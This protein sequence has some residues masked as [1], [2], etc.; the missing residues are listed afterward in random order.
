MEQYDPLLPNERSECNVTA[1]SV[2]RSSLLRGSMCVMP[3]IRAAAKLITL[4]LA[5]TSYTH[6][7]LRQWLDL[8]IALYSFPPQHPT[9][10][11]KSSLTEIDVRPTFQRSGRFL[12]PFLMESSRNSGLLG[13]MDVRQWTA[14][15]LSV[16]ESQQKQENVEM[17]STS[18]ISS[19]AYEFQLGLIG[20]G[21][22]TTAIA[23]LSS[24]F[25]IRVCTSCSCNQPV[26]V[27]DTCMYVLLV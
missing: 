20:N 5:L 3:E 10:V 1:L 23:Y 13:S 24:M 11:S 2:Q 26:D 4:S 7:P 18:L 12:S 8:I 6:R 16:T 15:E 27:R 9:E 22:S 21:R 19:V 25:E 17:N 14:H